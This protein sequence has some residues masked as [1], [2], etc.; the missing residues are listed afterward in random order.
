M[1]G[2]CA[3]NETVS[4]NQ[5]SRHFATHFRDVVCR[6]ISLWQLKVKVWAITGWGSRYSPMTSLPATNEKR[7]FKFRAI[8]RH[9]NEASSSRYSPV[10]SLHFSSNTL[11]H[12]LFAIS[13]RRESRRLREAV[14]VFETWNV[15]ASW[16][17]M[18]CLEFVAR[19][20]SFL[21]DFDEITAKYGFRCWQKVRSGR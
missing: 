4:D 13:K 3:K 6:K 15:K 16:N 11:V 17:A 12:S 5:G 21:L 7:A 14:W 1:R 8:S 19:F 10:T 9:E 18:E 20:R 2:M